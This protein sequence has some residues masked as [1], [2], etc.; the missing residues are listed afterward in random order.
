MWSRFNRIIVLRFDWQIIHSFHKTLH[1]IVI[2]TCHPIDCWLWRCTSH[3]LLETAYFHLFPS[4][5]FI[6]LT[7]TNT[8]ITPEKLFFF[9]L[10]HW[11]NTNIFLHEY[12]NVQIHLLDNVLDTIP[13]CLHAHWHKLLVGCW[14]SNHVKTVQ[15]CFQ[16]QSPCL[17]ICTLM[18]DRVHEIRTASTL[19][20]TIPGSIRRHGY[21]LYCT[22]LAHTVES[23]LALFTC[24][25]CDIIP[26]LLTTQPQLDSMPE[27]GNALV[28]H[29][30]F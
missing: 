26:L 2:S 12:E 13:N 6:Q 10:H 15:V 28:L 24:S 18:V 27:I 11:M 25:N 9:D 22:S 4:S 20:H 14:S 19:L 17:Q 7:L 3:I 29:T 21:D 23:F 5:T 1:T 8:A 16:L 30:D